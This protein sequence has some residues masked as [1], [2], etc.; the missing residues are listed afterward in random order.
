MECVSLIRMPNGK[1]GSLTDE[2]DNIAVFA[3][4]DAAI[5][6]M[7]GHILENMPHQLVECDEL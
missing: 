7:R 2:D 3:D 6:A 4:R 1:I 5:A